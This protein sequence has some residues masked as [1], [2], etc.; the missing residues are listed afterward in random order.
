[1]VFKSLNKLFNERSTD[2]NLRNSF[3]KLTLHKHRTNYLKRSFIYSGALLWNS[4]VEV[5][6]KKS[7]T[8]YMC[9]HNQ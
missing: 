4:L 5:F 1:M 7:V 2:Y 9:L 3:G 6:I 8:T